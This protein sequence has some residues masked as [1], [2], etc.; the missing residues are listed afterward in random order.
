NTRKIYI[1][2]C[3]YPHTYIHTEKSKEDSVNQSEVELVVFE[4]KTTIINC[5]YSTADTYP[6]LFWYVQYVNKAPQYILQRDPSTVQ[7]APRFK[8]R[9]S[10]TLDKEKK[11][12]LLFIENTGMSDSA[13]YYCA[14]RP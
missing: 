3:T 13:V 5:S 14:L 7:N 11:T 8:E 9:F 4:G 6:Y 12:T 2:T 1:H 10:A